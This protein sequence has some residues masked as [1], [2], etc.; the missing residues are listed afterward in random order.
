MSER[1]RKNKK[2]IYQKPELKII[3]LAADEVLG[4]GC[5]TSSTAAAEFSTSTM[6]CLVAGCSVNGS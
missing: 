3:D 1:N 5:K 6:G 4:V 2:K